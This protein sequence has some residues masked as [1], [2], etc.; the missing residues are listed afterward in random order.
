[1]LDEEMFRVGFE[2]P[3]RG[4]KEATELIFVSSG[5]GS[6]G[7]LY[8]SIM[9]DDGTHCAFASVVPTVFD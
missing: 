3:C 6:D 4:L 5:M 9:L 8:D 2:A 7:E 1:M